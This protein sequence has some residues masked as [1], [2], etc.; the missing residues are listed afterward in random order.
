MI[1]TRHGE[2]LYETLLTREERVHAI[3]MKGYFRIPADQR[4]L[5]YTTFLEEGKKVVSTA[6]EYN[7]HNAVRFSDEDFVIKLRDLPEI[8]EDLKLL[9]VVK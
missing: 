5:N 7:S 9:G 6:E 8:Q 3:D 4:D 1:G 2:K